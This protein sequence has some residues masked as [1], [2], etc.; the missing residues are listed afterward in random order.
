MSDESKQPS[1]PLYWTEQELAERWRVQPATVRD[2]R[3]RKPENLP[4]WHKLGGQILFHVD[5]VIS[6]EQSRRKKVAT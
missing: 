4:A 2:W 1:L 3:F 6:F 5:D